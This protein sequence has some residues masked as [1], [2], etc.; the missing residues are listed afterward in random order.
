LLARRSSDEPC[1]LIEW[2]TTRRQRTVTAPLHALARVA[3][4]EGVQPPAVL[5]VGPT[6]ALA[7]EIGRN[8]VADR[9]CALVAAG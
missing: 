7:A 4:L 3:R 9:E 8:R 6:A 5:V 2:A 1:A